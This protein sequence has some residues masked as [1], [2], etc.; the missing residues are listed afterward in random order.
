MTIETSV[1]MKRIVKTHILHE[2]RVNLIS[3]L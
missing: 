2:N 3:F 1:D